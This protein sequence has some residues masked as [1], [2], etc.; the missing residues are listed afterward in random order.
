VSNEESFRIDEVSVETV[1]PLR[2][3]LLRPD[4]PEDAVSYRSDEDHTARHFAAHDE[5]GR[6]VGIGSLHFENR[7]AGRGPFGEPGMRIR[8]MAVDDEWRGCGVG[9]GLLERML[10]A[11]R[12]AGVMEAWANARTA[13]L[14]F[15]RRS[16]FHAMSS[17]F[18]IPDIGPHIV[19]ACSLVERKRR[20]AR[21]KKRR[22][23]P[24]EPDHPP[25]GSD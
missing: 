1:R 16:G 20:M 6:V 18:E 2:Q 9:K 24:T 4:Q 11:G 12:E 15:Y 22:S 17:E 23:P 13:T 10:A 3:R 8:G 5:G 25:G 7:V 21:K 14:G 19:M